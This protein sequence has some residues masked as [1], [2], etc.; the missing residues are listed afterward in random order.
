MSLLAL[1]LLGCD[2][3]HSACGKP[4]I[5]PPSLAQTDQGVLQR[6]SDIAKAVDARHGQLLADHAAGGDSLL[7][8]PLN[9]MQGKV[10]AA[11][12]ILK[13]GLLER[14]TEVR[15]PPAYYRNAL[16]SRAAHITMISYRSSVRVTMTLHL[17]FTVFLCRAITPGAPDVILS[18]AGWKY[19]SYV[20][21]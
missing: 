11:V 6:I 19:C 10:G 9:D 13:K 7:E 3:R 4:T 20:Q 1:Q 2:Q 18:G 12:D 21:Q 5:P 14:E 8:D 15:P 16:R 17:S